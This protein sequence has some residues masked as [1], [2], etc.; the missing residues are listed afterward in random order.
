MS[1]LNDI[2][3]QMMMINILMMMIRILMMMTIIMTNTSHTTKEV[4]RYKI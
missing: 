4:Q 2:V 1:T 3:I